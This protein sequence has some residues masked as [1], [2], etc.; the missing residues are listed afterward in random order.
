MPLRDG[1][2]DPEAWARRSTGTRARRSSRSRTSTARSRTPQRAERR[3]QGAG[4]RTAPLVDRVAQVDPITLGVLTPPGRVRRG[5]GRRRGP[6]ARQPP[7]LRRPLV[8]LVRRARG[9]PAADARAHRRGDRRRGRAARVRAH[10]ADA[11]AAHPPREGDLEHLHL[12][13]AQRA[14]RGRLPVLAR[15]PRDRRAGRAAA[16]AHRT[17]RARRCAALEGVE[18]LHE[19]PVVREFAC[20]STPTSPRCAAAAPP[21]GVNPGADLHA[22]TRTRGGS[23][24]AAGGD[25]RAALARRH[26]PARRGAGR[27]DRRRGAAAVA[28]PGHETLGRT[29]C[30]H[31]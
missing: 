4:R 21:Q 3:G 23:R 17:T 14:R 15:A 24:R 6:A 5:R 1:V 27:G 19:Q 11:R 22:L 9:V 31:A 29:R 8:R 25:H 13:G 10:A 12:A 30:V 18:K 2:T 28:C 20:A 7:R 26:R 16:R